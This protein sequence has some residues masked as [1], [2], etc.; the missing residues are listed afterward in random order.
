MVGEPSQLL[1]MCR[2]ERTG[3]L[4]EGWAVARKGK[5]I[6]SNTVLRPPHAAKWDAQGSLALKAGLEG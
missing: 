4:H 3:S 1:A 5:R 6:S 2:G